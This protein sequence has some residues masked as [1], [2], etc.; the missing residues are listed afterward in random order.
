MKRNYG[1]IRPTF[2]VFGLRSEKYAQE[3]EIGSILRPRFI[4]VRMCRTVSG[5]GPERDFFLKGQRQEW[6]FS[7]SS[8]LFLCWFCLV[9]ADAA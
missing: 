4:R 3:S 2:D 5:A 9:L 8:D 1:M 7:K 6:T